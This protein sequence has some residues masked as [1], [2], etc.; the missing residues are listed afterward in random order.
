NH[1]VKNNMQMLHGL[2]QSAVREVSS[3]EA[4]AVIRNASQRVSAMAA[5]QQLL[6]S[7]GNPRSFS[8]AGFLDAV[9]NS[10]RNAVLGEV[11]LHLEAGDGRLSNDVSMPLAL[12]L[13]ELLTNAARHGA[14]A[15][16][17]S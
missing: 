5:A 1:R 9:C 2:L 4:R 10:V 13:N 11:T 12:I 16:G 6:Y 14:G 3:Q 17:R 15:D 7:D 8:I